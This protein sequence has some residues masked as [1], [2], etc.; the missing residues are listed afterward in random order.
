[1]ND[2]KGNVVILNLVTRLDVP[3]DR[4]LNAALEHGLD[5]VVI[6]GYDKDGNEYFASSVADGG[7]A[8]WLLERCKKRLL[9]AP[10]NEL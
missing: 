2:N 3:A 4:V 10:E 6:S 5:Q 1:M 9:E 8:L 7:Q